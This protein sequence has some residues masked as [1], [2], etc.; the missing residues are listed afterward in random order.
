MQRFFERRCKI[1]GKPL[2]PWDLDSDIYKID[3]SEKKLICKACS[4]YNFDGG[5]E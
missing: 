2:D 3:Y 1:C 5:W 4:N